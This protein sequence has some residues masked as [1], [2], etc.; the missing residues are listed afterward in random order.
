[1][2]TWSLLST[3]VVLVLFL[4]LAAHAVTALHA[5][6][7]DAGHARKVDTWKADFPLDRQTF[8]A[9]GGPVTPFVAESREDHRLVS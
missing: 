3:V 7:L 4:A 5:H 1:M 9:D 8:S 2:K 6:A